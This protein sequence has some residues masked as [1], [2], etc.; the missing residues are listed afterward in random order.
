MSRSTQWCMC[1]ALMLGACWQLWKAAHAPPHGAAWALP[2]AA[3][4]LLGL[5]SV[6]VYRTHLRRC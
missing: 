4:A 1:A 3:A 6:M 5:A 2:V